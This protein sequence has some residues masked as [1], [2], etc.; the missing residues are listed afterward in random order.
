MKTN[1]TRLLEKAGIHHSLAHYEVDPNDLSAPKVA[2][3][4][5]M[6]PNQVY[7]TLL[8]K[9]NT[10]GLLFAVLPG[11]QEL[12]LKVLARVSGNR[13]IEL[14]PVNQLQ[15]LTG[16]IRG[17]VTALAAKKSF[18]VFLDGSALQFSVI[19]VSAGIRG[20]QILLAPQDYQR[21][22][23]AQTAVLS[24]P[25]PGTKEARDISAPG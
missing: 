15:T 19:A 9:G 13:S 3:Q 20:T 16:Y 11:D 21:I 10:G 14:V 12:D 2:A 8:A 24:R 17:G 23:A 22:T 6:P 25:Q 7:K 5:G 4:I 18:P 1:A